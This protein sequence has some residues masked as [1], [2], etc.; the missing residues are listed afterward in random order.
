MTTWFASVAPVGVL[1]SLI[2]VILDYWIGKALLVKVY[3]IP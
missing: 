3:K 2:G 1:I